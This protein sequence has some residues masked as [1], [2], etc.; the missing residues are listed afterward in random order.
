MRSL[1][2][3]A[4]ISLLVLTSCVIPAGGA[5]VTDGP[6][7]ASYASTG[8]ALDSVMKAGLTSLEEVRHRRDLYQKLE[9]DLASRSDKVGD[10]YHDHLL[11]QTR[12]Q[13]ALYEE[14]LP[15]YELLQKATGDQKPAIMTRIYEAQRRYGD[16]LT[17][18]DEAFRLPDNAPTLAMGAQGGGLM[19]GELA[20]IPSDVE[21]KALYDAGQYGEVVSR[22]ADAAAPSSP[23]SIQTRALYALSLGREGFSTEAAAQAQLL[24]GQSLADPLITEL[25]TQHVLWL[26]QGPDR[27]RAVEALRRL[28]GDA[29][30][31]IDA[32]TQLQAVSEGIAEELGEA[33]SD[34]RLIEAR[35]ALE[36]G[37]LSHARTLVNQV[38]ANNPTA[39]Q[40]ERAQAL[41]TRIV[42]EE[43]KIFE[44]RLGEVRAMGDVAGREAQAL[45]QLAKVQADFPDGRY[46]ERI[47]QTETEIKG[48]A[49]AVP[50][51]GETARL[52]EAQSLLAGG[53]Y[54]EAAEAFS[55]LE[56]T[57]VG[58][59]ARLGRER[60]VDL[61]VQQVRED[62]ARA[63]LAARKL[64]DPQER[65]K[66]L[67]PIYQ[68]MEQAL[69]KYP[70]SRM[71]P[72]MQQNLAT[73]KSEIEAIN[74]DYFET[75]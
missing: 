16:D 14:L 54:E 9:R 36:S 58:E 47:R 12:R 69:K 68:K 35:A 66:A 15:Q 67:V 38:L 18:L 74:P 46:A 32:L 3:P 44:R 57:V 65:L 22:L 42:S 60:A 72:K 1:L 40:K 53:R 33:G 17:R 51:G 55:R 13:L 37:Q 52:N 25:R 20:E 26:V 28:D 23:I 50:V 75:P 19:E 11:A 34:K 71:A 30:L 27:T 31:S 62:S 73:V 6:V 39:D 10:P 56:T 45:T 59:D 49:A 7:A 43:E 64:S 29:Q 61:Y 2:V 8:E 70:D 21:V 4:S 41:Q 24:L 63:Y 48:K 5:V